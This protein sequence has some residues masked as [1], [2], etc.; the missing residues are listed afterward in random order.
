MKDGFFLSKLLIE[1]AAEVMQRTTDAM[2]I[3][4]TIHLDVKGESDGKVTYK[5]GDKK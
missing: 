5:E 3:A 4:Q 2:G 1:K